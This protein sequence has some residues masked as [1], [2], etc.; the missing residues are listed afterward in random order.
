MNQLTQREYFYDTGDRQRERENFQGYHFVDIDL[1]SQV[2]PISFQRSDFRG[3][4]LERSYFDR[5]NFGN[6]DFIDSIVRDCEFSKCQFRYTELFNSYFSQTVFKSTAFSSA[7]LV[8]LIFD[9]SLFTDTRFSISTLRDCKFL[10]SHFTNCTFQRS[11]MDEIIFE[12]VAFSNCDLSGMTSMNLYFDNCQFENVT[13]DADYLGSYFFK[14]SIPDTILLK[15]R[16][17]KMQLDLSQAELLQ[18]LCKI[19]YE[20]GRYYEAINLAIQHN[21][22]LRQR[23]SILGM[24]KKVS[25]E[26]LSIENPLIR[27]YQVERLFKVFEYY[28]NTGNILIGDYFG[29]LE[30]QTNLDVSRL[31][32]EEIILLN[33]RVH[34]LEQLLIGSDYADVFISSDGLPKAMLV[35]ARI[36]EENKEAFEEKW[37][38][39]LVELKES[40]NAN[41][42]VYYIESI[43]KGSLIYAIVLY[44]FA[45]LCLLRILRKAI[46]EIR[47]ISNES[48]QLKIDYKSNRQLLKQLEKPS[49]AKLE[50]IKQLQLIS[51][52]IVYETPSLNEKASELLPFVQQLTIKPNEFRDQRQ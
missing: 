34:R 9:K 12:D 23:K 7:S 5:N 43:R 3:A 19:F 44:S 8:R 41:E 21:M 18:N 26:L 28:F 20:K 15:Y 2:D 48:M 50:K 49:L 45:G 42:D 13:I 30:L 35:E 31:S 37:E 47:M 29:F 46:K 33:E 40:M 27:S 16:G 52:Q 22:L 4:L 6:A 10:K 14:G 1:R 25:G 51:Q 39:L 36:N 11:S 38:N 24:I 17:K 32:G